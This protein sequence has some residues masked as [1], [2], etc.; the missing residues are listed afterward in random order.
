MIIPYGTPYK[1]KTVIA[2]GY[3]DAVHVGHS[4]V[5]K[6]AYELAESLGVEPCVLIFTG[7]KQGEGKHLFTLPERILKSNTSNSKK[8][9]L[10]LNYLDLSGNEEVKRLFNEN[11]SLY[12]RNMYYVMMT[13]GRKGCLVYFKNQT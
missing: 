2:L 5:L 7:S 12:L 11:F 10:I 13:R 1:E 3:F 4:R 8:V 9:E 6:K